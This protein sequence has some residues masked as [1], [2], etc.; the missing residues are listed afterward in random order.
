MAAY[1]LESSAIVKAYAPE[2]GS[3][4]V[5]GLS[6][7]QLGHR[8]QTVQLTGPEVIAALFRQVRTKTLTR[9]VAER[10][11]HNFRQT[12]VQ[13]YEVMTIT[14]AHIEQA[15]VRVEQHGLRGYDAIHLAVARDLQADRQVR[16]L[17]PLTFVSA[18]ADQ[19]RVAATLG[20]PT[21]NPD[22]H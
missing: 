12:W 8:L 7:P 22:Q 15:M 9:P 14:Q 20:L 17:P 5:Q 1:Y 10:T 19:L 18:D 2:Q 21:E 6:D 11:A 4:W 16:Q 3:P 13:Q